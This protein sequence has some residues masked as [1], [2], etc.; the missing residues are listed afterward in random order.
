[1]S[2]QRGKVIRGWWNNV[3]KTVE[4]E[5]Q[6]ID[7]DEP[8]PEHK[9]LNQLSADWEIARRHR[10]ECEAELLKA[11]ELEKRCVERFNDEVKR[12]GIP[13]E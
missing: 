9:T 6:F 12:L 11:Q 1:M 2:T 8:S 5:Y 3:P 13:R 4:A 7:T 10:I